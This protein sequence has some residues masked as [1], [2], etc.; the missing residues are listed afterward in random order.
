MPDAEII[1]EVQAVDD[2]VGD[3]E[4]E[5]DELLSE[6]IDKVRVCQE[7]TLKSLTENQTALVAL[8]SKLQE[9]IATLET[10]VMAKFEALTVLMTAVQERVTP[11]P[12][13]PISTDSNLS[14]PPQLEVIE[15]ANVE[16]VAPLEPPTEVD[17][18]KRKRKII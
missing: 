8:L 18:P 4:E 2:H 9:S 10:S 13:A 17:P 7:N 1:E 3:L 14:N 12:I 16:V 15:A 6:V 5:T 11:L